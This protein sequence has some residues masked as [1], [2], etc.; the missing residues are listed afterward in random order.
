M[1]VIQGNKDNNKQLDLNG[2]ALG[3]LM[4]DAAQI[5]AALVSGRAYDAGGSL[6]VFEEVL[7]GLIK[8]REKL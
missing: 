3:G 6:R 5:T 2:P 8:V 1:A 7:I 4:H